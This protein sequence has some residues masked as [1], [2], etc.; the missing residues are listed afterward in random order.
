MAF[1][2]PRIRIF[3]GRLKVVLRI[4]VF[5]GP[6]LVALLAA[7]TSASAQGIEIIRDTEIERVLYSYERPLLRAAGVDPSTI[8]IYL[9]ADPTINA[10]AAQSPLQSE[11]EDIFVNTGLLTQLK[12]PNEVKGVLAHETGH[13][14]G[15][16][17][18]RGAMAMQKATIPMLLGMLVGVVAM[19]A[20]GGAAGMGAFVLGQQAAMSQYLEFS[21]AQESTADQRGVTY[22]TRTHQSAEGML[23]VFEM[24]AQQQRMSADFNKTFI[25]DH[26]ADDIRIDE[27]RKRVDESPYKDVKDSPA[28]V[29]EFHMIQAKLIGY[30]DKPSEVLR[31]YPPS[32]NSDEA[33]YARAMAYF[34]EP[35]FTKALSQI[36]TLIKREPKNPYF[37]EMYGQILVEM[38]KPRAGIIPYQKA[39]DL[40]PDAPL[41][42]VSLAAA[43]IAT[44][45]PSE[46][47]AAVGN[48]QVAMQ[49]D[50]TNTFGWYEEA[51]AYSTLGNQAMADLATA[52]RY[53]WSGGMQAAAMFANRAA[54]GLKPGTV[55]WQRASDIISTA[56]SLVR[57]QHDR[58]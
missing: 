58:G 24:L 13:I 27:L 38:S 53:Y 10:F 14:A 7:T 25:S 35:D 16:D 15:G 57:Q 4:L 48:L 40:L 56:T 11:G 55:A 5:A 29:H 28:V 49:Q 33:L 21:R 12:T 34:R 8:H 20:G 37:W 23:K 3:A 30:L 17:V 2:N 6:T 46:I 1:C 44:N 9:N 42:R 32:N 19:V 52:E 41:I 36:Q 47:K 45:E 50:R 43:Q 22:L 54:H 18:I 31:L 39:V 26:P 51:Q